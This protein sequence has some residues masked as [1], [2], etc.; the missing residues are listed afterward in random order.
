MSGGWTRTNVNVDWTE[1]T[2]VLETASDA[3]EHTIKLDPS[4]SRRLAISLLQ[5]ADQAEAQARLNA[6]RAAEQNLPTFA[7]DMPSAQVTQNRVKRA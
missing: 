5:C 1:A 2:V 3:G 4:L 7:Q 6:Q